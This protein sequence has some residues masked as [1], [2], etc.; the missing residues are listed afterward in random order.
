MGQI[1]WHIER[2]TAKSSMP[3]YLTNIFHTGRKG[4]PLRFLLYAAYSYSPFTFHLSPFFELSSFQGQNHSSKLRGNTLMIWE[5]QLYFPGEKIP[6]VTKPR[7]FPHYLKWQIK[8]KLSVD[9]NLQSFL[10][11]SNFLF[12]VCDY[13]LNFDIILI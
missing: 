11:F 9:N 10:C 12:R 8:Y 7:Y 4:C 2:G 13:I 6:V 5:L 1:G 3:A